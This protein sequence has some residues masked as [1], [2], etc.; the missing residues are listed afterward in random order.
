MLE[1][2]DLFGLPD[3]LTDAVSPGQSFA[4]ML[5]G[6]EASHGGII[7][8]THGLLRGNG[9]PARYR[10]RVGRDHRVAG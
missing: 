5:L 1:C 7:E 10:G 3:V 8:R 2:G 6:V 4:V 9:L